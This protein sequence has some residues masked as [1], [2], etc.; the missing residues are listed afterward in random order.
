MKPT[1]IND[2]RRRIDKVQAFIRQHWNKPL[3]L[4][5]L[6]A[7]A[8]LSSYHFHRI[9]RGM[10][11]ETVIE[12]QRRIRLQHAARRL[13]DSHGGSITD[14]AFAVGYDSSQAFA[15]AFHT[16]YGVAPSVYRRLRVSPS[17]PSITPTVGAIVMHVDVTELP[18]QHALCLRHV[19]PYHQVDTA[20]QQLFAWAE[21]HGLMTP[22]VN[23]FGISYDDPAF[24][25]EPQ[26]RYDACLVFDRSMA[27]RGGRALS[28][29]GRSFLRPL[30]TSVKRAMTSAPREA[31]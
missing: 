25:P 13:A 23:V 5:E 27:D 24:V 22:A 30:S 17:A 3:S 29:S 18:D 26:L 28:S 14:I 21:Q 19:G 31:A 20:F 15:R 1:T 16:E 2:Y 7:V 8:C 10:M 6:A 12:T 4:A 11:G 9:Y